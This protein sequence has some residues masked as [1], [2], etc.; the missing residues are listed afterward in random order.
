MTVDSGIT[1]TD[2]D[3]DTAASAN[4]SITGNFRAGE[5]VLAFTNTSGTTRISNAVLGTV[6]IITGLPLK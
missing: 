2:G 1:L 3:S 5:D 6:A 4:V